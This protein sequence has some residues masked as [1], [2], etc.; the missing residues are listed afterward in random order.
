MVRV[1][2]WLTRRSRLSRRHDLAGK[3][4]GRAEPS[5][6][7]LLCGPDAV[8]DYEAELSGRSGRSASLKSLLCCVSHCRRREERGRT[9]R[10]PPIPPTPDRWLPSVAEKSPPALSYSSRRGPVLALCRRHWAE[11]SKTSTI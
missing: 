7:V 3:T 11:G 5:T 6:C 10:C 2:A 4:K 1:S 8:A 9:E